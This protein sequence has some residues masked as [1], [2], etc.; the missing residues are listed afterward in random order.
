MDTIWSYG[1]WSDE[2][3]V[4][5]SKNKKEL[6]HFPKF[7]HQPYYRVIDE[8]ERIV[9]NAFP[10]GFCINGCD[11]KTFVER[12]KH[13]K[14]KET[15]SGKLYCIG[16]KDN[17]AYFNDETMN[18]IRDYL[19]NPAHSLRDCLSSLQYMQMNVTTEEKEFLS[20]PILLKSTDKNKECSLHRLSIP[21]I[22]I[23]EPALSVILALDEVKVRTTTGKE[24]WL[25]G[26]EF[27]PIFKKNT[28]ERPKFSNS[29]I[30]IYNIEEITNWNSFCEEH[31]LKNTQYIQDVKTFLGI[32]QSCEYP[33]LLFPEGI[34]KQYQKFFRSCFTD[35]HSDDIS[36]TTILS[37]AKLLKLENENVWTERFEPN[38]MLSKLP[39]KYETWKEIYGDK[40]KEK[41]NNFN[42][43]KR[44][45]R[46]VTKAHEIEALM[47][48]CKHYADG[49]EYALKYEFV[50]DEYKK[51]LKEQIELLDFYAPKICSYIWKQCIEAKG[52]IIE[53]KNPK[54]GSQEKTLLK[55]I[56]AMYP[57]YWKINYKKG[58][59]YPDIII[60]IE[61]KY[62]IDIEIDEPYVH[63]KD[64][65]H[66]I[67]YKGKDNERNEYFISE[68]WFV[69]RFAE[70]N[71]I[72]NIDMCISI[73]D[74]LIKFIKTGE[75]K[76]LLI[77]KEQCESIKIPMWSR[78]EGVIMSIAQVREGDYKKSAGQILNDNWKEIQNT[79]TD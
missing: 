73:L 55:A 28:W 60:A 8:C 11:G 79:K 35:H 57:K 77:L 3:G 20:I 14:L 25:K 48:F 19:K 66:S 29:I 76:Y 34:K 41:E 6:L 51:R 23:E 69:L 9:K 72:K 18:F 61:N 58:I 15:L 4:V 10:N 49:Y 21:P 17:R 31:P 46:K 42:P 43:L 78:D 52:D 13:L 62:Y 12:N 30:D 70:E 2:Y 39:S 65:I 16:S 40:L 74:N 68:N 38:G 27:I 24:E 59:Y 64:E 5:Y 22:D 63:S 36:Y 75:T 47:S 32:E 56:D 26:N 45:V 50:E 7:F 53:G 71:V 67:H 1:I 37:Y 54:V 33:K 44:W